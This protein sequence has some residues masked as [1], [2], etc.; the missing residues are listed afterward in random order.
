MS[1]LK[2]VLGCPA[3]FDNR[4]DKEALANDGLGEVKRGR[5]RLSVCIAKAAESYRK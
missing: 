3:Q 1:C 5:A 4:V 2:T